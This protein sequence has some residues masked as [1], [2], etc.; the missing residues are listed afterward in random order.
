MLLADILKLSD[1]NRS[2]KIRPKD[3][4]QDVRGLGTV[5]GINLA[6]KK[7]SIRWEDGYTDVNKDPEDYQPA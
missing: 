1:N 7:I 4:R 6:I 5:I 2:V 3:K